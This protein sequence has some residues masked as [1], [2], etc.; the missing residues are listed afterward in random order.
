MICDIHGRLTVTDNY[1]VVSGLKLDHSVDGE[2]GF[3]LP[4]SIERFVVMHVAVRI[5]FYRL[6]SVRATT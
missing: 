3:G 1:E 5:L 6:S 4:G 2:D